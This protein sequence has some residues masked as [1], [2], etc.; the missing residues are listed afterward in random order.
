[1]TIEQ[2]QAAGLPAT[3]GMALLRG[4]I[5][6]VVV[7]MLENRS[8]DH[9]LGDLPG[10]EGI[11]PGLSNPDFRKSGDSLVMVPVRKATSPAMPYDPN[12]EFTDVKLQLSLDHEA[13]GMA[14]P[15]GGF[16]TSAQQI[17]GAN[18]ED[19]YRVM[20]YFTQDQLPAL[21]ALAR[22]FAVCTSWHSSL[23]GPTFP[24]RFFVHAA[25]SGGLTL[26]PPEVSIIEGFSFSGGTVYSKLSDAKRTWRIYHDGLP[27]TASINDLRAEY[28]NPF[29]ENFRQMELFQADVQAGKLPDYTFI[30]PDYDVSHDYQGGNSMHP[31]DDVRKGEGLVKAVY[32]QL[33]ASSYWGKVLFLV[34]F[35]EHG[36][37][38]DHVVPPA[39]TPPGGDEPNANPSGFAF[40]RYGVRVPAIVVSA[41]TKKGTVI[42]QDASGDPI[43]FDHASV[44]RTLADRFDLGYLT[45]RSQE[46]TSLSVA[47]NQ[48]AARL[49]A[50]SALPT[51]P[52]IADLSAF[53]AAPTVLPA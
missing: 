53:G 16:I 11:K 4:K 2:D 45:D 51:L 25:T 38:Y 31:R 43:L 17:S 39:A 41:Y 35:D 15:M 24:N 1:M 28:I 7:L 9:L 48:D 33:R 6:N 34:V 21:S 10:V 42:A 44:Y 3:Q 32:E 14:D 22:E 30:E 13:G 29:T 23:P 26:S 19:A 50:A 52:A 47:L 20:E 18:P 12:H 5:Q 36:G 27:Q 49:D 46:A 8:F 40:D 37:F